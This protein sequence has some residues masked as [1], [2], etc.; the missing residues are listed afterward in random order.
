MKGII[1]LASVALLLTT[2]A[3]STRG[4]TGGLLI[5]LPPPDFA[6]LMK[7]IPAES[8]APALPALPTASFVISTFDKSV[9]SEFARAWR[10]I[11]NGTQ[12]SEAVILILRM[13]DGSFSA[14]SQGFTNEYKRFTFGWHP[15]TVAIV[16]THPNGSAP[17]PQ[18]DDIS[19]A[20]K[21]RVP[22]F[23]LTIKGMFVYDPFTKKT[24]RVQ[25]GLDWLN[26]S[27]WSREIALK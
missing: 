9:V 2:T 1:K 12:P 19:V 25:D 7:S 5:F 3:T 24:S 6:P 26:P 8:A 13:R 15:A 23:T 16:H 11:G 22:I 17:T 21:Y 18:P 4:F 20:E 14:R 27:K 10:S